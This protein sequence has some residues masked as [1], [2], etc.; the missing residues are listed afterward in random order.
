LRFIQRFHARASCRF[1]YTKTDLALSDTIPITL[2]RTYI[3]SDSNSRSF[4]IA[5]TNS[6]DMFLIADVFPYTFQEL[7]LNDG[8]R[9]RFD[10]ISPGTGFV[11]AVYVHA[12]AQ[13]AFYGARLTWNN[14][15]SAQ[16]WNL[17]VKDGST[18]VFPEASTSTNPFCQAPVQFSDRYGNT[19]QLQ[20][21]P[22]SNSPTGCQLRK[23][24]SPNGRFISL[25][26]DTQGR[27]TQAQDNLGRT[28]TYT[29]DAPGR[30]STV[31]DAGG[32]V[33]TYTYNDQN[34]MVTIQDAR[35]IVY[36]TNQ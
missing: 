7:I 9:I 5:F 34:Q 20:R 10:R 16:N 6:Y 25:T 17:V 21:D 27:I 31:T 30:L 24:V 11:D 13:D 12:S 33:T 36:L 19:V 26:H 4:G 15:P 18:F 32:G 23:I 14:D 35:G 29:Y 1:I 28:V 22:K 8:A 2:D 3:T